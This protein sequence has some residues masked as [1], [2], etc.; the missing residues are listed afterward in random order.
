[1][2]ETIPQAVE[3][4]EITI[5]ETG[6]VDHEE[7][8]R[9]QWYFAWQDRAKAAE[10]SQRDKWAKSPG[11][12]K[13]LQVP[14]YL[15]WEAPGL[16]DEERQRIYAEIKLN[17]FYE[18]NEGFSPAAHAVVHSAD[19]AKFFDN[20]KCGYLGH[21]E[22]L[23]TEQRRW[24]KEIS[25]SSND[26]HFDVQFDYDIGRINRY[27]ENGMI[28]HVRETS[29]PA[30]VTRE[31][32]LFI[33]LAN[34]MTGELNQFYGNSHDHAHR[35]QGLAGS[36]NETISLKPRRLSAVVGQQDIDPKKPFAAN[37]RDEVERRHAQRQPKIR[38][39]QNELSFKP[40]G[41]VGFERLRP[42][43]QLDEERHLLGLLALQGGQ[44][45]NE[46][47]AVEYAHAHLSIA[48]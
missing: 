34:L 27:T 46:R 6:Y 15:P 1:M 25:P 41:Y 8:Q 16:E 33:V 19:S 26:T 10:Q 18:R 39:Q 22:H 42:I 31:Q 30:A 21:S 3:S 4:D 12:N 14:S 20:V 7:I 35:T 38:F 13:S 47:G 44:Y 40:E 43:A 28:V 24:F 45:L 17:K 36:L 48:N 37:Y 23:S 2:S 9:R 5:N 32:K 29:D 11:Y